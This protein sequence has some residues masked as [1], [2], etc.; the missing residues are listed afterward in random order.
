MII[1]D[2]LQN[3]LLPIANSGFAAGNIS[4]KN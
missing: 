1:D 3:D 2:K 4:Y